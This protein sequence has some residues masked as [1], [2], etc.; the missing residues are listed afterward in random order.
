LAT[1][2]T[3]YIL[4]P[5]ARLVDA[6]D[7]IQQAGHCSREGAGMTLRRD[8]RDEMLRVD[9]AGEY[10]AVAIYRGQLAVFERQHGK[11]RIVGQ[12]KEMA[13]QEQEHLDAFDRMLG[14]GSVRPTAMSPVWNAA[15]FALGVGTALLGEKAAHACTE[16]VETVIEEHYCD[17]VVELREA[18]DEQLADTMAKF[19]E[20]E[21]SHKELAASEGAAEAPAYPLLSAIIRTGCRLAIRISEKV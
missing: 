8:R 15:G 1:Y 11:E 2:N 10:G 12:L 4:V 20:E 17:Q 6:C 9:H 5:S 16:A 19:Q 14:A 21:V 18:G 13:A 7:A 3:D